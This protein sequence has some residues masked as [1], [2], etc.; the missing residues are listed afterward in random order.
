MALNE[1]SSDV[2]VSYTMFYSNKVLFSMLFLAL[3]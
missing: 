3:V 1:I 2:L